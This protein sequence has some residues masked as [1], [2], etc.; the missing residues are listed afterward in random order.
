[1]KH[2]RTLLTGRMPRLARM[3]HHAHPAEPGVLHR[4]A[5]WYG[6]AF[7]VLVCLMSVVN[8]EGPLPGTA[9]AQG[10]TAVMPFFLLAGVVLL[11]LRLRGRGSGPRITQG[12]LD[13]EDVS[14]GPLGLPPLV[15]RWFLL[16]GL[17]LFG[18]AIATTF[19]HRHEIWAG[20]QRVVR[21]VPEW[22]VTVPLLNGVMAMLAGFLVMAVTSRSQRTPLLWRLSALMVPMT[23]I[24]WARV[25]ITQGRPVIRL[26]TQLGNAAV[27]P[28]VVLLCMTIAMACA[29]RRYRTRLSQW[30]AVFH[31][32][33]LF[34]TA[35]RGG[36]VVLAVLVLLLV[37]RLARRHTG[38]GERLRRLPPSVLV[39]GFLGVL[40][41]T[42]VSPIL[43][44]LD[45]KS[46][47]LM[48]WRAGIAALEGDWVTTLFGLGSGTI[49]PW[50]AYESGW[51]GLPGSRRVWGPF[52]YVLYHAHSLYVTVLV[53]L[54]ILGILLLVAML[55]PLVAQWFRGGSTPLVV[56]VSGVC[57]CLVGF[58]FD[59]Y[60]FKNFGV[61]MLW[62]TLA[63]AALMIGS[64][65]SWA[66]RH[67]V[68]DMLGP[69]ALAPDALAPE[70]QPR[71][72]EDRH[73][74]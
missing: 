1:M 49:W 56:L 68:P 42:A 67:A 9:Y 21:E 7:L 13:P 14:L 36:L 23:I 57:A 5:G 17:A 72:S 25:S 2:T 10:F 35:S 53:E 71:G 65:E 32:I 46:G 73:R 16:F 18:W 26:W 74:T 43:G 50:F 58:T 66:R 4:A 59:L 64:D 8:L 27:Y 47:R 37:V 29:M 63:F 15:V 52:G 55:W 70:T 44:R 3:A 20:P 45:Q 34:L 60:L 12:A 38:A 41:A 19:F 31:L 40:A 30:I 6:T 51:Q 39:V 61:S 69:D 22:L 11:V 33:F 54:G 28:I 24:G 48:S 62:W